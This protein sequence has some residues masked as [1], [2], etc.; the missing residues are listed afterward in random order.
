T[1]WG[2]NGGS[3]GGGVGLIVI[4]GSTIT[5]SGTIAG[6]GGAN[7]IQLSG[8]ANSLTLQDGSV[9]TGNAVSTSGSTNGGDG[10]T[11]TGTGTNNLNIGQ[12]QGF[13]SF[14]KSGSGTWTLTGTSAAGTPWTV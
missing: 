3:G 11:L 2:P 7:A 12:I 9:L 13:T 14:G 10:L 5:N 1:E 8:G 4:G 6:A